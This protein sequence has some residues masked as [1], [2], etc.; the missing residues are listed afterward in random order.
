MMGPTKLKLFYENYLFKGR[1]WSIK[2]GSENGQMLLKIIESLKIF[3]KRP[4]ILIN[5]FIF[6]YL[7]VWDKVRLQVWTW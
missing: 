1:N 7:G 3:G 5:S 6:S 2:S 4:L